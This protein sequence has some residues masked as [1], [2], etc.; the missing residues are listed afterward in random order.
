LLSIGSGVNGHVDTCHGGFVS[1]LLDEALGLAADNSRPVD[2]ITMTA[3][4]H[5]SEL[6]RNVDQ[7]GF[8][9]R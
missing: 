5:V 1:L 8:F 4:L 9:P 2:K 7:P 3:Y 6:Q